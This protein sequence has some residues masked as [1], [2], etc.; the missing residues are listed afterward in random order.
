[1]KNPLTRD[2]LPWVLFLD[3]GVNREV[4]STWEKFYIQI[5]DLMD[6]LEV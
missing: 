4:F 5:E 6:C 3:I 1:M 2:T